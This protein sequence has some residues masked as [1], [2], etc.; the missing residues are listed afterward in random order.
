VILIGDFSSSAAR[1]G[2]EEAVSNQLSAFGFKK[3]SD[4]LEQFFYRY[5]IACVRDVDSSIRIGYTCRQKLFLI[6][7][8]SAGK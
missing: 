7:S 1:G 3:A 8:I 5:F 4:L 2:T 6:G